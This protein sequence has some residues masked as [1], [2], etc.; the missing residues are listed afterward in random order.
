MRF[1]PHSNVFYF[2]RGSSF[3]GGDDVYYV[4]QLENNTTKALANLILH[5]DSGTFLKALLSEVSRR[6]GC[7][8]LAIHKPRVSLQAGLDRSGPPA[9]RIVLS[10]TPPTDKVAAD[11]AGGRPDAVISDIK[12]GWS[13]LVESKLYGKVSASQ[14]NGHIRGCGWPDARQIEISWHQMF[15]LVSSV[16]EASL[17]PASRFLKKQWLQYMEIIGMAPFRGF[18]ADDLDFFVHRPAELRQRTAAKMLGFHDLVV[19]EMPADFRKRFSKSQ[20]GTLFDH[21]PAWIAIQRDDLSKPQMQC[22]FTL[23]LNHDGVSAHAVIRNG[24]HDSAKM[25]VNA[26][27]TFIRAQPEDFLQLLR[28]LGP[29]YYLR[30]SARRGHA[31]GRPLP[32]A[33]RWHP[34]AKISLDALCETTPAYV[35]DLLRTIPY[36]GIHIGTHWA[37][38]ED[39]LM[40]P[41]ELARD[42]AKALGSLS[43]VL[44]VVHSPPQ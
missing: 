37:R 17:D 33:D 8:T 40:K 4:R 32:G 10:L 36:P 16:P 44:K 21:K 43:E 13:V 9:T 19:S 11:S 5:D 35:A 15:E 42:V 20:V 27:Y 3:R 7:G 31:G 26:L 1:D 23:E 12:G 38:G 28:G 39:F 18:S 14:I 24:R 34:I 25:P 30:I 2:Y 22:N 6:A 41:A 29:D